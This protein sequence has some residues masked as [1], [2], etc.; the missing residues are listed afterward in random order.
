MTG[1]GTT[2]AERGAPRLSPLTSTTRRLVRADGTYVALALTGRR[3]SQRAGLALLDFEDK[4]G[5]CANGTEEVNTELRGTAPAGTY[6]GAKFSVGVPDSEN[7]KDPATAPSPLNLSELFWSWASGYKFARIDGKVLPAMGMGDA[8]MSMG[9]GGGHGGGDGRRP[10]RPGLVRHPP[11]EQR[12]LR[13]ARGRTG[14]LH[15]REPRR[16]LARRGSI[17]MRRQ[18]RGL[19]GP[20]SLV[21]ISSPTRAE[22]PA[23]CRAPT[24]RSVRVS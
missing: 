24:I 23:A 5:T 4:T 12:M 8:G 21:S 2:A 6:T 20:P 14:H 13:N 10:R 22:L 19:R 9:D 11:R 3:H 15:Q 1:L 16:R 17:P 18:L 7:F